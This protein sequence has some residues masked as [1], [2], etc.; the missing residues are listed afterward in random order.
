MGTGNEDIPIIL[1]SASDSTKAITLNKSTTNYF[2]LDQLATSKKNIINQS[3]YFETSAIELQKANT[4][5]TDTRGDTNAINDKL[6]TQS[7]I[8]NKL[9]FIRNSAAA[10]TSSISESSESSDILY[11]AFDNKRAK[12]YY[13]SPQQEAYNNMTF[14]LHIIPF[15]IQIKLITLYAGSVKTMSGGIVGVLEN[16]TKDGTTYN[17]E[18][19]TTTATSN[20]D[21]NKH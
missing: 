17:L 16:N 18:P 2:E 14:K 6:S 1:L 20:F 19:T 12:A 21:Y 15:K 7:S 8:Y 13:K 9:L 3:I 4:L 5:D 10:S 11:L